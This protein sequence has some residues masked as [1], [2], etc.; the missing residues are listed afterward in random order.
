MGRY[1]RGKITAAQH[2][3]GTHISNNYGDT[4]HVL[5]MYNYV[6]MICT[7]NADKYKY[8]LQGGLYGQ[9]GRRKI[10][11]AQHSCGTHAPNK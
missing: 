5:S 8:W 10:T 2:S 4:N 7:V 6:D 9:N 1:G 3:C 11:A